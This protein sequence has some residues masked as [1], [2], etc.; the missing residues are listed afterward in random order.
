MSVALDSGKVFDLARKIAADAAEKYGREEWAVED[1]H[2]NLARQQLAA[3]AAPDLKKVV[4]AP[5]AQDE[6]L[7]RKAME[8]QFARRDP[9]STDIEPGRRIVFGTVEG[10]KG[11]QVFVEHDQGADVVVIHGVATNLSD[12]TPSLRSSFLYASSAFS[13]AADEAEQVTAR[14]L[15]GLVVNEIIDRH[16]FVGAKVRERLFAQRFD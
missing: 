9:H 13:Q 3:E 7:L 4:T 2:I 12:L 15:V 14:T 6:E 8:A 1:C 10:P 16:D 5:T 11:A